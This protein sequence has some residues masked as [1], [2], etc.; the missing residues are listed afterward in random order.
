[1]SFKNCQE[2]EEDILKIEGKLIVLFICF[3]P[4]IFT[5]C[6]LDV[7]LC[8]II[9]PIKSFVNYFYFPFKPQ[10]KHLFHRESFQEWTLYCL[11]SL[12]FT[13]RSA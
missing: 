1:M 3:I 10:L 13:S 7:M 8:Y 4:Q 2:L 6:W 5:E 11:I 9:I 12:L